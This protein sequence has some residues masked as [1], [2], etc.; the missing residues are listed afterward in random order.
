MQVGVLIP[1]GWKYEY[2]GWDPAAA[3]ARTMEL[4][5]DAEA[6]GFESEWV[7]VLASVY[8]T[9]NFS[10]SGKLTADIDIRSRHRPSTTST[11][12]RT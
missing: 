10:K 5:R 7:L 8:R 2:N 3:W 1:Q 6:L 12:C 4:T 11:R 9:V